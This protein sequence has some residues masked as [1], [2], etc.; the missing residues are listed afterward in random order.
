MDKI[1]KKDTN[2]ILLALLLLTF[3]I[4][5]YSHSLMII[6]ILVWV[7]E[8]DLKLKD[9]LYFKKV[10][11]SIA[12]LSFLVGALWALINFLN[13]FYFR[14]TIET[15]GKSKM[16][17]SSVWFLFTFCLFKP[18]IEE[19]FF[20]GFLYNLFKKKGIL[21]AI[22]LSS[23]LFAVLHLDLYRIITI[24]VMGAFLALLYEITQCFWIPVLAHGTG[25]A[26]HTFLVMQPA[27][28]YMKILLYWLHGGNMRLFTLKLFF[29]STVFF[30]S[31]MLVLL[32]IMRISGNN[33]FRKQTFKSIK[34][35]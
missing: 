26:I 1:K 10:S 17:L 18:L 27:A 30:I 21:I 23:T 35:N 13:H 15:I 2:L 3:I 24:F 5:P 7:N 20:R 31:A 29:I 6:A 22:I 25:N 9:I 14:F 32:L 19:L 4:S 33:I 12:G 16:S 28:K 34:S 8:K 11:A